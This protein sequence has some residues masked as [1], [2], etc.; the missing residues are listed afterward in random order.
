MLNK[1]RRISLR[2]D[3]ET[4]K[5]L[6]EIAEYYNQSIQDTI[7]LI[8]EIG[9]CKLCIRDCERKAIKRI[10]K[11]VIIPFDDVDVKIEVFKKPELEST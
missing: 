4:S 10:G 8:V 11:C 7:R 5:C 6:D 3:N 2:L 9:M 1:T